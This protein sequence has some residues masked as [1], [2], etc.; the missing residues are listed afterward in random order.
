MIL[1]L[2]F[3]FI[4]FLFYYF[5]ISLFLNVPL[6]PLNLN[7]TQFENYPKTCYSKKNKWNLEKLSLKPFLSS[8]PAFPISNNDVN[9]MKIKYFPT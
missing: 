1:H 3:A 8:L 4:I 9:A 6:Y 2:L 5:L 7:H